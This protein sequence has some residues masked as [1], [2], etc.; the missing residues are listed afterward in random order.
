MGRYSTGAITTGQAMRIELSYLIKNNFI[1]KGYSITGSLS[2]TNDST[3]GYECDYTGDTPFIRLNYTNTSYHTNEKTHHDYVINLTKTPSNLGVGEVLYFV[4]PIT[5][6]RCRIL[7]KCYGSLT[8]KSREAYWYRIY[9][10]TQL[11]PKSIRPYKYAFCDSLFE[12]LYRKKKKSHYRGK[13]TRII[14]KIEALEK[15]SNLAFMIYNKYGK[16]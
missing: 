5:G 14:K 1:K 12:E 15:R 10:Q 3:I 8:W 4:C 11:D 6:K 2:W 9:Y 13:P 7:Y 16:F